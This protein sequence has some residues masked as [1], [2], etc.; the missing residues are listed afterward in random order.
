MRLLKKMLYNSTM[1]GN[2]LSTFLNFYI[3]DTTSYQGFILLSF[4]VLDCMNEL[5]ERI[6]L[7]ELSKGGYAKSLKISKNADLYCGLR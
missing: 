2:L 6:I 4:Q 5:N 1:L 3:I 7:N